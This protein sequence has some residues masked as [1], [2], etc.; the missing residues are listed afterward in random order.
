[1]NCGGQEASLVRMQFL[2]LVLDL[3]S[4]LL[5]WNLGVVGFSDCAV[6]AGRRKLLRALGMGWK[7]E[8]V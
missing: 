5:L 1:M 8:A 4:A 2:V 7:A 3:R 6:T